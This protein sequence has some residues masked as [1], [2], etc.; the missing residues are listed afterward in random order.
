VQRL[1]E[2][3]L[4][5]VDDYCAERILRRF[6]EAPGAELDG[7]LIDALAH[8]LVGAMRNMSETGSS[9]EA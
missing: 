3:F 5:E 2:T 4:T 9:E 1:E 7:K 6:A 8:R